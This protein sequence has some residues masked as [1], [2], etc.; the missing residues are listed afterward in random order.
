MNEISVTFESKS[1]ELRISIY[2]FVL[3]LSATLLLS[4]YVLTEREYIIDKIRWSIIL[5]NT[6]IV[7]I[8][9][10]CKLI[11]QIY[12]NINWLCYNIIKMIILFNAIILIITGSSMTMI[13]D[14][15]D[16]KDE[17]DLLISYYVLLMITAW[18]I[19]IDSIMYYFNIEYEKISDRSDKIQN[20]SE[21][22]N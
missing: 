15:T 8:C 22:T 17:S 9:V 7:L 21:Y 1:R 19:G 20:D 3:L 18:S 12:I 11:L 5:L 13:I 4:Y 2:S 16:N 6:L 10:S 14:R